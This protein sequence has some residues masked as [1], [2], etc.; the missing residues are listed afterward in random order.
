MYFGTTIRYRRKISIGDGATSKDILDEIAQW[1]CGLGLRD[2][3]VTADT[4]SFRHKPRVTLLHRWINTPMSNPAKDQ[5]RVGPF[6]GADRGTISVEPSGDQMIISFD[7]HVYDVFTAVDYYTRNFRISGMMLL[8]IASVLVLLGTHFD[9]WIRL[10]VVA[11][12]VMLRSLATRF[13]LYF[14]ITT[15]FTTLAG[16]LRKSH[17]CGRRS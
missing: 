11:V 3:Q 8:V 4:V 15:A 9:L 1:L 13:L 16:R 5:P 10:V 6:E 7:V 12:L 2:I 17:A 14:G